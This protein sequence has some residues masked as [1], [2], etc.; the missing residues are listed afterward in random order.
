MVVV[1]GGT[2]MVTLC[3]VSLAQFLGS[4]KVALSAFI[5]KS[6]NPVALIEEAIDLADVA[7]KDGI[8]ALESKEITD[9]FLDNGVNL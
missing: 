1:V 3:Q 9:P 6:T 4:F 7:R 5:H 8:L 2:F